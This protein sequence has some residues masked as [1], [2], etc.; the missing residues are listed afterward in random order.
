MAQVLTPLPPSQRGPCNATTTG[1]SWSIQL[2]SADDVS[3]KDIAIGL[4]RICR[5]NGQIH[6][7]LEFFAVA[8]HS[9]LMTDWAIFNGVARYAEDALAILLHDGSE[10]FFGDMTTELKKVLPEYRRL[11]KQAQACV[12]EAFGL[13][14]ARVMLSAAA[15]KKIDRRML[16]AEAPQVLHSAAGDVLIRAI[17]QEFPDLRPLEVD[18]ACLSPRSARAQFVDCFLDCVEELPARDPEWL[19]SVQHHIDAARDMQS[20]QPINQPTFA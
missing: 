12:N 4:S 2:P 17:G 9:V 11:E 6:E 14:G 8:E 19:S 20:R 1:G 10:A 7:D 16:L 5:Y 15:I 13:T 18:I 3:F